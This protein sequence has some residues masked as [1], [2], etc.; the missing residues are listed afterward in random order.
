M[1]RDDEDGPGKWSRGGYRVVATPY[2]AGRALG[3]LFL[4]GKLLFKFADTELK[5]GYFLDDPTLKG[6]R[7]L[8]LVFGV[9]LGELGVVFV[10]LCDELIAFIFDSFTNWVCDDFEFHFFISTQCSFFSDGMNKIN[11][12]L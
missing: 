11:M 4:L 10:E 12:I 2:S 5:S 1:G 7:P 9:C 6:E 3:N 8:A